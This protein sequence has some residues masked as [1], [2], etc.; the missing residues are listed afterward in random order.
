MD[1]RCC[2]KRKSAA[3]KRMLDTLHNEC[4][5]LMIPDYAYCEAIALRYRHE[6]CEKFE[7]MCEKMIERRR[8]VGGMEQ[9]TVKEWG[10]VERTAERNMAFPE[11]AVIPE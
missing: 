7:E 2:R 3:V 4:G 8:A 1:K 11:L 9:P 5:M 6:I 10:M